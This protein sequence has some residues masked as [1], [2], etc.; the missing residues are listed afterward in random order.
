LDLRLFRDTDLLAGDEEAAFFADFFDA[1][2]LEE[3]DL[4]APTFLV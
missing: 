4:A 3:R 1:C 2:F